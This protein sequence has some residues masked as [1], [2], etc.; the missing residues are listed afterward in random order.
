MDSLGK[1]LGNFTV[2]NDDNIKLFRVYFYENAISFN[3]K[4]LKGVVDNKEIYILF[5][6]INKDWNKEEEK[7]KEFIMTLILSMLE[8]N[9]NY[10]SDFFYDKQDLFN[11]EVMR[12][13]FEK[14]ESTKKNKYDLYYDKIKQ[15]RELVS[16]TRKQF[17]SKIVNNSIG[18]YYVENF[19]KAKEA[20]FF[21]YKSEQDEDCFIMVVNERIKI[22]F[23]EKE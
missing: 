14:T 21:T 4:F 7:D 5:E 1:L 8:K 12:Q 10:L 2:T 11:E 16:I 13:E 15:S 18:D 22:G 19:E 17:E 6:E 3:T 9:Q 23:A 20:N